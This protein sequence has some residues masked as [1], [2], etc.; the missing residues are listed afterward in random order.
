MKWFKRRN[1]G[2]PHPVN[3]IYVWRSWKGYYVKDV[4][5][6]ALQVRAKPTDSAENILSRLPSTIRRFLFHVDLT[7]TT[8]F[9]AD[10]MLLVDMLRERSIS[11]LNWRVTDLR[12]R[13]IHAV[14][15]RLGLPCA[16]ASREGDA[17]ELLIIKTD[18]NYGG[19]SERLLNRRH[20]QTLGV[21]RLSL[22]IRNAF[23]Y[24]VMPRSDVPSS[25]WDDPHLIVE[26]FISNREHRMYRVRVCTGS[27][28]LLER[29]F[30]VAS[31]ENLPL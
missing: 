7:E 27:L 25:W 16:E 4:V 28:R 31:E 3:A 26:C 6:G 8:N 21:P 1:S 23:D 11:V 9:P 24:K 13:T 17:R 5:P 18:R 10:R 19:Y 22:P 14:T 30:A 20:R 29:L 2:D 12:K 15:R